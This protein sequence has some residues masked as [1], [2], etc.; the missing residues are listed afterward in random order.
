M[1]KEDQDIISD[2]FGVK[3]IKINSSLVSGAL[4]NRLY[5]TNIPEVDQ[6]KDKGI[7]LQDILESGYTDRE[8]ARSL[9]ASDSRPLRTKKR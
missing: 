6:P 7:K 3:P 9:L 5:W 1:S 8:K 2:L 4:R